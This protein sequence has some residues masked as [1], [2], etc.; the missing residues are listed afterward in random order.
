MDT[1]GFY[2]SVLGLWFLWNSAIAPVFRTWTSDEQCGQKQFIVHA[3]D[4][5]QFSYFDI[6]NQQGAKL[7][8]WNT[9]KITEISVGLEINSYA[10]AEV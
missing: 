8:A 4:W 1:G 6:S 2:I 7:M 3:L 9:P 10:C 5:G